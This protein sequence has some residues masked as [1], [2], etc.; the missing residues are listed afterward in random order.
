MGSLADVKHCALRGQDGDTAG[1]GAAATA[2]N[3]AEEEWGAGWDLLHVGSFS[4]GKADGAIRPLHEGQTRTAAGLGTSHVSP[5][6]PILPNA[7][8]PQ[9]A[10]RRCCYLHS[11]Q[12]D[13]SAGRPAGDGAKRELQNWNRVKPNPISGNQREIAPVKQT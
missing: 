12:P 9:G 8:L 1:A 10:I 11:A 5:S 3:G 13:V 2:P 6:H 4:V 7:A